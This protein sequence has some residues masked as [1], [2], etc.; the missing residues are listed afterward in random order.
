MVRVQG[1]A[2]AR[3]VDLALATIPASVKP[4]KLAELRYEYNANAE[5]RGIDTGEPYIFVSQRHYDALGD[6]VI[7]HIFEAMEALGLQRVAIPETKQDSKEPSSKIFMSP[8]ALTAETLVILIHGSGAVRAGM[9]ARAL[10]INDNL[11]VG[12]ML[13]YIENC[14]ARGWGVVVLNCNEN[15]VVPLSEE[16]EA[17][18]KGG[19]AGVKSYYLQATKPD[20]TPDFRRRGAAIVKCSEDPVTHTLYVFDTFIAKARAANLF[21]VAHSAG[22]V[23]TMRLLNERTKAVLARLKGVAFTDSVHSVGPRDGKKVKSFMRSGSVCNWAQSKLP[24]DTQMPGEKSDC[25]NVS[26]GHP[27]HEWTSSSCMVSVFA[28]LQ[29]RLKK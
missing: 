4:T 10:C 5:L 2:L 1:P 15:A 9:W 23:C 16:Q 12:S 29:A 25:L 20:I 28:F 14:K 24:L 6:C 22:G 19:A 17:A 18:E 13:P 11:R 26:A 7:E 21:I 3:R 27:I 8:D